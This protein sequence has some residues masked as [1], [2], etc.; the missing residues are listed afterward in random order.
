MPIKSPSLTGLM[1]WAALLASHAVYAE[2]HIGDAR[3][4]I[5]GYSP[6]SYFTKG[7]A[8]PG[9]PEFAVHTKDGMTYY[10]ASAEQVTL[11]AA[12]PDKYQPR[13]KICPYSLIYGKKLPLDPT[14][15]QIVGGH[16]LLFHR[17][18]EQGDGLAAWKNEKLTD[19]EL[20]EKADG[21]YRLL[22]F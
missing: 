13:Y 20:L 2:Q 15:F 11:F 10:L 21:A 16:L 5:E 6:V 12:D 7:I 3:L 14:N 4:A 9:S 1:L 8:E 22:S 17:S 19:A 18:E